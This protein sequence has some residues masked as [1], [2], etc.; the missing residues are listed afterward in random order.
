MKTINVRELQRNMK[1]IA[2]KVKQGE[3]F[4]VLKNSEFIFQINPFNKGDLRVAT[5]KDKQTLD[6]IFRDMQFS[7]GEKNLSKKIDQLIY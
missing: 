2:E 5:K 6:T 7:S 3:S 1:S 4:I